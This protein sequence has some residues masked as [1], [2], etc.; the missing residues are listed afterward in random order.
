MT[1]RK[2]KSEI[3]FQQSKTRKGSVMAKKKEEKKSAKKKEEPKKKSAAKKK[4]PEYPELTEAMI[5]E[6][7]NEMLDLKENL[8]KSTKFAAAA[9]RARKNTTNLERMF[10]VYRKATIGYWKKE[11]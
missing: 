2:R 6:I 10:K 11:E 9:K 3:F 4:E 1:K 8:E 7:E 5:E